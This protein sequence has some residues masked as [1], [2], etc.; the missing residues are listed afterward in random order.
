MIEGSLAVGERVARIDP[1]YEELCITV[2]TVYD[3]LSPSLNRA[4]FQPL[5]LGATPVAFGPGTDA[6]LQLPLPLP[7]VLTDPVDADLSHLEASTLHDT[8]VLRNHDEVRCTRTFP[9]ATHFNSY[10]IDPPPRPWRRYAGVWQLC[11]T[12]RKERNPAAPAPCGLASAV[13]RSLSSSSTHRSG[14]SMRLQRSRSLVAP[15]AGTQRV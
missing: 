10:K 3:P 12:S 5:S 11:T 6:W 8:R 2:G 4:R 15:R 7:L 14:R 13:G 1:D 9:S